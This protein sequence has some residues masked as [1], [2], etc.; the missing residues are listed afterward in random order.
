MRSV[1]P[2]LSS[3]RCCRRAFRH[4]GARRDRHLRTSTNTKHDLGHHAQIPIGTS[5]SIALPR[6][7]FC[8]ARY[9]QLC[10]FMGATLESVRGF[11]PKHHPPAKTL[12][13]CEEILDDLRK[14]EEQTSAGGATALRN[15]KRAAA[16]E[17]MRW[18]P[19]QETRAGKKREQRQDTKY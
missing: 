7:S 6:L 10:E 16:G 15:A 19:R 3:L 8:T 4:N 12:R 5:L 1:F 18:G 17:G 13:L 11:T 2:P 14:A 9:P